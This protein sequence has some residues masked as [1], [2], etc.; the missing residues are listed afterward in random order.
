MPTEPDMKIDY[1][2]VLRQL[3]HEL[4]G[5]DERRQALQASIAAIRRLVTD[6][7]G[8]EERAFPPEPEAPV[9]LP[10]VPPG[11]FKDKTPTQAYRDLVAHWPGHY[12]PPQIADLFIQGG[13]A[14]QERTA[15]IQAIHSVLKRE[16]KRREAESERGDMGLLRYIR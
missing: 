1:A 2:Q 12:T 8:S 5:I 10:V 6:S 11:F 14:Y 7:D 15:L 16:R 4:D 3:Q 13:I 9:R